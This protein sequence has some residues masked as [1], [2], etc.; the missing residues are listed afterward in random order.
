MRHYSL[1]TALKQRIEGKQI[2]VV[3]ENLGIVVLHRQQRADIGVREKKTK[4]SEIRETEDARSLRFGLNVL[5]HRDQA[6]L[7]GDFYAG[8]ANPPAV[9]P[10]SLLPAL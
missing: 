7:D 3:K 1:G 9:V 8:H 2:R 5:Y 4:R 10:G 6:K